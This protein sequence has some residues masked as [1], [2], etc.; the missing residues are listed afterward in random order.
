MNP[1]PDPQPRYVRYSARHQARLDAVT[2][3]KLEALTRTFHRKRA[4]ILR[5]VMQW[6]LTHTTVWSIGLS[7]PDRPQLV[8]ILVEPDLFQSVQDAADAHGVSIAAWL[9]HA[10]RQVTVEDFPAS[11]RAEETAPRSHESGYYHRKFG[12]RLD[13]SASQ[14]LEALTK[15]FHRPAAAVIRQLIVQATPEDFP[16]SWHVA[17]NMWKGACDEMG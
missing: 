2:H 9:R 5:Y 13:E 1:S 17:V 11:W 15:T 14:K 8:H 10:M 7:I 3:P 6:G 4:V 12:L 16:P